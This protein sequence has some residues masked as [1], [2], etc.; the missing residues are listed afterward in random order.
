MAYGSCYDWLRNGRDSPIVHMYTSFVEEEWK[1]NIEKG[2]A[3][4]EL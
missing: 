3:F 2:E 1:K 4:V